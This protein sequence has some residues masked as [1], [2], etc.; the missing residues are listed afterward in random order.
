MHTDHKYA[1]S[2]NASP[3]IVTNVTNNICDVGFVCSDGK[4]PEYDDIVA[5]KVGLNNIVLVGNN[6]DDSIPD[7]MSVSELLD[8]CLI[9]FTYT[10]YITTVLSDNLKKLGYNQSDVQCALRVE[11]IEG[12]K[13]LIS[14]KFGI[15]FLPYIAVKEELYKKQFKIIELSEFDMDIDIL[16]LHKTNCPQHVKDFIDWF[17]QN[18]S[19]SF[20]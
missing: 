18:G 13:M 3:D 6:D 17:S 16:M 11:G 19:N 1:L 15:A 9:T 14:R 8:T 7:K 5:T 4:H 2:G 10:N 12:A 20:C